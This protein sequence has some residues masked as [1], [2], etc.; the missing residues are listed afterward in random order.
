M[1]SLLGLLF[2][3]GVV[4]TLALGLVSI[5]QNLTD[6]SVHDEPTFRELGPIFHDQY[7][8]PQA[9]RSQFAGQSRSHFRARD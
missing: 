9:A 6:T 5:M 7:V 8:E 4:V 2:I 1:H 3:F